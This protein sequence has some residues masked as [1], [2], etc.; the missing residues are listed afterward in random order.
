M[1]HLKI[2]IRSQFD[3]TISTCTMPRGH[4]PIGRPKGQSNPK[5]HKAGGKRKGS[6]R[7]KSNF[8]HKTTN[9]Y[10]ALVRITVM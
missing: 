6:G 2:E 10:R 8:Q 4:G 1:I 7:K 9:Y 5:N 3:A